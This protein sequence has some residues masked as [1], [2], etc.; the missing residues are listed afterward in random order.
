ML[1]FNSRPQDGPLGYYNESA[2]VG[3]GPIWV[4]WRSRVSDAVH[5]ISKVHIAKAGDDVHVLCGRE[6]QDKVAE[7][8]DP[9]KIGQC[10]RCK[11]AWKAGKR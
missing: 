8:I 6:I 5:P 4:Q 3:S 7:L 1:R 11:V 10:R 9:E 2:Y